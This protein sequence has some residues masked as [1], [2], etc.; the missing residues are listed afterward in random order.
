MISKSIAAGTLLRLL[1]GATFATA[2]RRNGKPCRIL[3]PEDAA[4]REAL[5]DAHLRGAAANLEFRAN[6]WDEWRELVD[7]VVLAG[8]SPGADGL[9]RWVG[10][11]L[12]AA[13]HG[14]GGLADPAHAVRGIAGRAGN[15]GLLDGL[16]VARSRRGR[17]RH[18]FLLPPEPV[19]LNDAVIGVASLIA[20]A[21]RVAESD[22]EQGEIP[23]AFGCANGSI[24]EPGDAGS[25][26]LIPRSTTRP[27]CGW[28]LLLPMAGAFAAHGGG[29]VVDPFEEQPIE[30]CAVPHCNADA[31]HTFV[32][33]AWAA[34]AEQA[35]SSCSVSRTSR[36]GD[37]RNSSA[38]RPLNRIDPRTRSF[39][40]GHAVQGTRNV[41]AFAASAN[42]LACGVEEHEAERLILAGAA[43]CGLPEPEARA[44]FK[45]A[46]R[47]IARKGGR[48]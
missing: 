29:V 45:S 42:L 3:L 14:A 20:A 43:A 19:P 46:A 13:D 35:A 4:A 2:V 25:V 32:A 38:Q 15:A 39:L 28:P 47:A 9:C 8:Y 23:H 36:R 33:E 40:D 10:I 26:E 7:A 37:R 30:C 12:D 24:A 27:P 1:E 41:S 34:L 31:W 22:A 5:V 21:F 17:G 44:A 16:L 48:R 11:D 6:N 18:V